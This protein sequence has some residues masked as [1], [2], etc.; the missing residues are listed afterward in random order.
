MRDTIKLQIGGM[1]I[2]SFLSYEVDGNILTP[3][4]AFACVISR[5]DGSVATGDEFTLLVNDETAM[6]GIVDKVQASYGKGK[7][8]MTIEGRDYMG[9]LVDSHIEDTNWTT[10]KTMTLKDIAEQLL[11]TAPY[12]NSSSIE[13]GLEKAD[14]GGKT[15][16]NTRDN[17]R[18]FETVIDQS[19]PHVGQTIFEF[20]SQYAQRK[21]LVFWCNEEGKLIFGSVKGAYDSEAAEYGFYT[22]KT[23]DDRKKNNIVSARLTD[24][25]SKRYSK[26][27]VNGQT[28]GSDNFS[29]GGHS[30]TGRAEDDDF[31]FYK[32][33]VL[34]A[35][36]ESAE[37]AKQ[38]AQ[39]EL[40]KRKFEGW[41]MEI[42]AAGHSQNGANYRA[43]KVCRI[44]D[45]VLGLDD[46][47]VIIGRKFTLDRQNGPRTI[48][49]IGKLL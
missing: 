20:L 37:A 34:E 32:P 46:S 13:Y 26:V 31:P 9:L 8:E 39:W 11:K 27:A 14:A 19:Q 16:K 15:Q 21:G 28:Q 38:Q 6:V 43:N 18:L 42:T 17:Q 7:N 23:G 36:V 12:I 30:I 35:S 49:T 24:D 4:D 45:E 1:E 44:K 41:Q 22:Y 47:F 5:I 3:A 10:L 25:I 40:N 29:V 48:L 2:S 33:L